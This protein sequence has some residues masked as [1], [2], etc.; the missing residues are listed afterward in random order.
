MID[1][2]KIKIGIF[3]KK[4][5]TMTLINTFFVKFQITKAKLGKHKFQTNEVYLVPTWLMKH[6]DI[7]ISMYLGFIN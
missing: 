4:V 2:S 6:G 5:T 7:N 3:V 1:I